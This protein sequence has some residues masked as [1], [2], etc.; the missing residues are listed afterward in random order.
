MCF[1]YHQMNLFQT[2][3]GI[4]GSVLR[5]TTLEGQTTTVQL[6]FHIQKRFPQEIS[7]VSVL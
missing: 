7:S 4:I 2:L 5:F 6:L 3:D 1:H